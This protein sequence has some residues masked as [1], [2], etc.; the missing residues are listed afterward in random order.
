MK[1]FA[2]ITI[3]IMLSNNGFTQTLEDKHLLLQKCIDLEDIQQYFDQSSNPNKQLIFHDNGIVPPNLNAVKFDKPVLFLAT[4]DLFFRSL[5]AFGYFDKFDVTLSNANIEYILQDVKIK[6][7][8]E[9]LDD[10]WIVTSMK[11]IEK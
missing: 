3:F 7:T 5:K 6:L 9:K 4:E 8:F 2:S 10:Y 11:I 1:Q